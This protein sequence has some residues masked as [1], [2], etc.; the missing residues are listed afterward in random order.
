MRA[1]LEAIASQTGMGSVSRLRGVDVHRVLHCTRV[2][3]QAR[4]PAPAAT[5]DLLGLLERFARRL[6]RSTGYEEATQEVLEALDDLFGFRH[7]ILLAL[8]PSSERLFA[9]ASSGDG[10]CGQQRRRRGRRARDPA[11]RAGRDRS[12]AAVP[13]IVG[14]DV[15]GVL[16]LESEENAAFGGPIEG[17]LHIVGMH[18]AATLAA[19][20]ARTGEEPGLPVSRAPSTG[21][22][23]E[24]VYYQADDTV[25]CD[26]AYSSR[27]RR[28]ASCG[29]CSAPTRTP[30]A[31]SLQPRA[32]P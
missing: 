5:P 18:T 31:P 15:L 24:L 1:N 17:L 25:L 19:R 13:L 2:R 6:E 12:A 29:A 16:Y 32:T 20:G 11:P 3:G 7:S 4:A 22:S 26:S 10:R 14:R 9:I 30:G 8:D 27:A 21:P 28:V 23:L